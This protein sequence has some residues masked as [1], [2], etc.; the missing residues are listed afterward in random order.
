MSTP[1][2]KLPIGIQTLREILEEGRRAMRWDCRSKP[3]RT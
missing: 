2:K 1:L 3:L